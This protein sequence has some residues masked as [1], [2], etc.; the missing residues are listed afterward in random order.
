MR[1]W[2]WMGT[3]PPAF[4]WRADGRRHNGHSSAESHGRLQN[5]RLLAPLRSCVVGA[6]LHV[7]G[8]PQGGEIAI[9]RASAC[10]ARLA[11]RAAKYPKTAGPLG[12]TVNCPPWPREY[13]GASCRSFARA[14]RCLTDC[15][16]TPDFNGLRGILEGRVWATNIRYMNDTAS[17]PICS[18]RHKYRRGDRAA[19]RL[20]TANHD[21]DG[22]RNREGM[23]DNS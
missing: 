10:A 15:C 17:S 18:R 11:A 2:C 14:A 21:C 1:R 16:G 4:L 22:F 19:L 7:L 9:E 6:Y 8:L 20:E 3:R 12:A 13:R 23:D 5:Q